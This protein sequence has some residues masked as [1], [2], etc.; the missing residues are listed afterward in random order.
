MAY[1]V[2]LLDKREMSELPQLP[3]QFFCHSF[4][5]KSLVEDTGPDQGSHRSDISLPTSS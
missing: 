5:K 3:N 2:A 1:A 4:K